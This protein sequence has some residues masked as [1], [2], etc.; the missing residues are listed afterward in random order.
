MDPRDF[1]F[2]LR[3]GIGAPGSH[4]DGPVDWNNAMT[5]MAI[6]SVFL[7]KATQDAAEYARHANRPVYGKDIVLAL[8]YNA[9]PATGFWNSDNLAIKVGEWRERLTS[10]MEES[11]DE[12]ESVEEEEGAVEEEVWTPVVADSPIV[13]GMNAAEALFEQWHPTSEVDHIVH[14]AISRAARLS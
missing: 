4:T 6:S 8:K 3:S 7:E 13:A 1:D 5:M 9:L 10:M 14:R 12:E 11:S 2:T